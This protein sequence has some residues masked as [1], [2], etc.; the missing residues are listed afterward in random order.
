MDTCLRLAKVFTS[1]STP[2]Y[3]NP[4]PFAKGAAIELAVPFKST[5][6]TETKL[7]RTERGLKKVIR[8]EIQKN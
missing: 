5:D 8:G 1:H 7:T 3:M 2:F 4:V 6:K